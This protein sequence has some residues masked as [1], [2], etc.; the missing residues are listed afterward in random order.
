[1]IDFSNPRQVFVFA[2]VLPLVDVARNQILGREHKAQCV[3]MF[4]LPATHPICVLQT[5]QMPRNSVLENCC[6]SGPPLQVCK[7]SSAR[8]RSI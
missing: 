1:M 8:R 2:V 3:M 6:R 4:G 7:A 5:P